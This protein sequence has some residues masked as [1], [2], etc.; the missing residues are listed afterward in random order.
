MDK[1][2]I[3]NVVEILEGYRSPVL[4]LEEKFILRQLKVEDALNS[5]TLYEGEEEGKLCEK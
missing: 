3:T 1:L 2:L 5:Q 4:C